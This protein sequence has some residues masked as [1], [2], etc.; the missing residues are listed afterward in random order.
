MQDI[1]LWKYI[2]IEYS[3]AV[4][5]CTELVRFFVAKIKYR[6]AQYIG[7]D[8]PKWISLIVAI[9]LSIADW[10]FIGHAETFNFYQMIISFSLS[11]LG[12]DYGWKLIKDQLAP[13]VEAWTKKE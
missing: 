5:V 7:V 10:V 11:V 2:Y 13:L 3:I 1:D 6:W 8:Q 4:L 12:Y 9:V